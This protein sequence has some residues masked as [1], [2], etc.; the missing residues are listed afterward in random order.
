MV[1][2]MDVEA[3]FITAEIALAFLATVLLLGKRV[4]L[5][6]NPKAKE[7][8]FRPE[9]G[10]RLSDHELMMRI[11]E[12]L[13]KTVEGESLTFDAIRD[14]LPTKTR[15]KYVILK[16]KVKPARDYVR[17]RLKGLIEKGFILDLGMEE[18]KPIEKEEY[19]KRV[20]GDSLRKK[21]YRILECLT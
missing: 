19:F 14:L 6:T 11:F 3:L 9:R 12:S 15:P 5:K 4:K 7:E 1:T 18:F 21:G 20:L 13:E 2:S 8:G 16:R 10:E 17:Q